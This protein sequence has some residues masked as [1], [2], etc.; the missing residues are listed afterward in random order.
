MVNAMKPS[1]NIDYHHPLPSFHVDE[2]DNVET[3]EVATL[4]SNI[5]ECIEADTYW[6]MSNL[7]DGIQDNY[8]FAQPGI[9]KKV[10][11][12]RELTKRVD[13]KLIIL[14]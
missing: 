8:T 1:F 7:L 4:D 14:G 12:L 13:G 3:F 9:Q 11:M 6:C 10:N 5:L 2:C